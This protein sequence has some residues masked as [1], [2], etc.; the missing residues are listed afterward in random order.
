MGEKAPSLTISLLG[1]LLWKTYGKDVNQAAINIA[2]ARAG[3]YE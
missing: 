2:P 3:W 1:L